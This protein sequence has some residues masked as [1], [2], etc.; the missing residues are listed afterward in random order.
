MSPAVPANQPRDLAWNV[1]HRYLETGQF[2]Q[3]LLDEEF[4]RRDLAIGDRRF[5]TELVNGVIRRTATLDCLISAHTTRPRENVEPQLWLLLQLGLY[6][7]IY[8]NSVPDHAA[9]H[10]TVEQAKRAGKM[11]WTGIL[12]G[13]LRAV[14]RTLTAEF[15]DAPAADA[16]PIEPGRYRKLN[17]DILPSPADEPAG[18]LAGAFS[19]PDWLVKRW[20]DRYEWEDL[21]AISFWLNEQPKP[22]LRVNRLRSSRE[23]FLGALAERE[24]SA[25]AGEVPESVLL[26]DRTPIHELPGYEQGWF[27]VQDET[28]MRASRLLAP[29]PGQSV[30]DLCAAPGTKTTH[31]AELM[32]NRGRIVACDIR[33][34]RLSLVNKNCRRLGI[35]VVETA[36]LEESLGNMPAG[37]FDAILLDVP[38]SNTGVLG[39]RPEA[40]WR[41]LP[42]DIDELAAIQARLCARA[43]D[44]LSPGG[45]LVY[46]TCSIEPEENRHIVRTLLE[47]CHKLELLAEHEY[48]PG[49]PHD[50]GYQALLQRSSD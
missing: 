38:C 17:R 23:E 2:A 9:V 39:K 22:T 5:M 40:R 13:V 36:L 3:M 42:K 16:L 20:L 1:L 19:F 29:Q 24:I 46:S 15:T 43:I 4:T 14:S 11:R 34:D 12:N 41:L 28:A 48:L 45:R 10:E 31:L 33:S 25:E 44:Q 37:P 35:D 27:S 8:L 26:H 18:Y 6:Q 50:G 32:E 7:L 47:S 49:R 30:L 21:L